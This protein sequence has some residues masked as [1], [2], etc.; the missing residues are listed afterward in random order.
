MARI[1][2]KFR[3]ACPKCGSQEQNVIDS[4]PVGGRIRRRREC[5]KC[6]ERFTTIEQVHDAKIWQAKLKQ[7]DDLLAEIRC[8]F[9]WAIEDTE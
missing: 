9:K 4:R 8:T 6:K 3:I 2:D 7:L 5:D 1:Y